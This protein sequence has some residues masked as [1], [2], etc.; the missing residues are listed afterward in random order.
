MF[1]DNLNGGFGGLFSRGMAAQ[2]VHYE[3]YPSVLI[4]IDAIL[5]GGALKSRIASDT[6]APTGDG[7]HGNRLFRQLARTKP[8]TKRRKRTTNGMCVA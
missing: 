4:H 8:T 3:E 6:C 1:G 2:A 7:L 5:V